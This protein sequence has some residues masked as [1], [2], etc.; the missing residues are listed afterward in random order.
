VYIC[1]HCRFNSPKCQ[2]TIVELKSQELKSGSDRS[3]GIVFAVVFEIIGL[4]SLWNGEDIRVWAL[5][6]V[7][8]FLGT[9]LI[10]PKNLSSLNRIWFQFSLLL[11]EVVGPVVM[12]L[13]FF[14]TVKPTRL[15]KSVIKPWP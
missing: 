3:F 2:S 9:G 4:L 12:G 13:I 6:I 8:M 1:W 11:H 7:G 10:L 14:V 5:I 15:L